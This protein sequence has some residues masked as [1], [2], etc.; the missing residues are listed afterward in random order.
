MNKKNMKGINIWN[1]DS[2]EKE[3]NSIKVVNGFQ[4]WVDGLWVI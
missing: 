4:I 1:A 2:F 3:T